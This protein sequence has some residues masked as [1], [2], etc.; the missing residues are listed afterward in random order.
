[1]LEET[2]Q[3][4]IKNAD[5]IVPNWRKLNKNDLV[6]IACNETNPLYRDGYISAIILNY[7]NK[8]TKYC[9]RCKLVASPEDVHT[10]LSTSVMY[11]INNQ[12]WNDPN[13]SVY[14]DANGPDKVINRC[15]ESRRITFYQQLNRYN[16]KINSAISSLDSISEDFKDAYLPGYEDQHD[17]VYNEMI[18][19]FFNEKRYFMAFMLDIIL[20]EDVISPEGLNK[21]KLI[22][23]MRRL[24]D[25]FC[26]AF[27]N[28]YDVALDVVKDSVNTIKNMPIRDVRNRVEYNLIKFRR[29]YKKE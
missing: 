16:R 15:M 3:I 24:D 12:P 6:R 28:R 11:A 23:Y 26:E 2:R 13:S 27:S 8:L 20:Y 21:K 22:Y 17:F 10:W 25:A 14:Q 5:S 4:Y 18:I 9:Y 19:K 7:W 29:S 1:M